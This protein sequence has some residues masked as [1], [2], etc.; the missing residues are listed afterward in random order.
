MRH[1]AA[2]RARFPGGPLLAALALLVLAAAPLG[3]DEGW[4]VQRL[5]I[6]YDIQPDGTVLA[7]EAIDVD[8]RGL[9]RHGIYRDLV[10]VV[11]YDAEHNRRYDIRLL[12]V[13]DADGEAYE[14]ETTTGGALTRF[15]IGDPD[16][17]VSGAQAYRLDYRLRRALNAFPDHDEL[18]WNAS[19]TWPVTVSRT[20]VVVTAPPGAID[21]VS[22][23]QGAAGSTEPCDARVAGGQA[24]FTATRPLAEGEQL[25]IVAGLVKGAVAEPEPLLVAKPRGFFGAFAVTPLTLGVLFA[26]LAAVIGG[27]GTLW[28]RVGRD[29]RYVSLH[30][31]SQDGNEERVPLFGADPIVVE[32]EPPDGL[33]P[34]QMGLLLDERADTLDVTATI[35]DLA[36]RGYLKITEIPK[37][38]WF[39]STDWR[40]DR[41]KPADAALLEYERIV[42]DGLF[43]DGASR[44]LS[45]LKQ[46]FYTHL[47]TAKK[48]LY[49]DA[50]ERGWFPRNPNTVRIVTRVV[51]VLL[52]PA[53]VAATLVLGIERGLGLVGLPLILAAVLTLMIAGAMPRRTAKGREAMRRSLGFARYVRTGETAQ[54]AFAERANLFTAYLPYAVVFNCVEKWAR[55]FKDIDLQQA[56]A[57]WYAGST[58]FDAH[59][60]SSNLGSFSSSVSQAIASTPGGSGGSGFS[61]GSSGGG[62]GG[63]G[64]GSW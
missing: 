54:Q 4:V 49:A 20:S 62:G 11:D 29:R 10:T 40:L 60:F 23:F 38:G 25:T 5:E 64:G 43:E 15:R 52:L 45:D 41:L 19:G 8:F 35:V 16:R 12:G 37:T 28:W 39:G 36:A 34:A 7:H 48:A 2:R 22:C 33:R 31:L 13:T 56:T 58:A 51:G 21:R 57:G 55:A 27:L 1:P 50:L 6:R 53:G 17:T 3:A 44:T 32:F 18:Y 26:G 14:V 9:S 30:Y 61:G 47:A 59:T 46:K 24:T 42:L 63:G